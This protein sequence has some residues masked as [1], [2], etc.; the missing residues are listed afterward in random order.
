MFEFERFQDFKVIRAV[1]TAPRNWRMSTD[2][3]AP[4]PSSFQPNEHPDIWYLKA[5]HLEIPFFLF[6]FIPQN[7]VCFE[8]H[9]ASTIHGIGESREASRAAFDWMFQNS[10][11]RRIVASIPDDNSLVLKLARDVGMEQYGVNRASFLRGG[12]LRDQVLFGISK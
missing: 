1:L 8:V 6:T 4:D 5:S 2:D 9:I 7:A 3:G 10:P 11:A 12:E